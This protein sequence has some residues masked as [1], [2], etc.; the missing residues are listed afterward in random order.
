MAARVLDVDE[1][2]VVAMLATLMRCPEHQ[3]TDSLAALVKAF[4]EDTYREYWT[5]ATKQEVSRG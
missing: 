3:R 5:R 4:A 1:T 2:T